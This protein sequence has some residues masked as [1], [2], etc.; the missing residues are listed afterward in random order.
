MKKLIN[1]SFLLLLPFLLSAQNGSGDFLDN[2]G[3]IYVVVGV[4][5]ILFL[6]IVLFLVSLER[7][8]SELEEQLEEELEDYA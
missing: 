8:V 3:K 6:F 2:I 4:L 5:L 1:I 7:R